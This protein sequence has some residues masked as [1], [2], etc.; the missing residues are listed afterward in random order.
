MFFALSKVFSHASKE[1][2]LYIPYYIS[3]FSVLPTTPIEERKLSCLNL[4]KSSSSKIPLSSLD[5]YPRAYSVA[6]SAPAEEPTVLLILKPFSSKTLAA[7]IW[8][9]PLAPPPSKPHYI[10]SPY[11][12]PKHYL[13]K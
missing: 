3:R 5:V 6:T 10:F 13:L 2:A 9:I 4:A 1:S 11:L 12:P 8:A 7:S